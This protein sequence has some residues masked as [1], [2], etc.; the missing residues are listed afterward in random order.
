[1]TDFKLPANLTLDE[2]INA[3][4]DDSQS[5][6]CINCGEATSPVE[7]DARRYECESCGEHMVYGAEELL[8]MFG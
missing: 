6:F 8:I 4:D 5:G 2:I 3:V 1:M 7:P